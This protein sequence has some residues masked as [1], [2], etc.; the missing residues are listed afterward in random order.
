MKPSSSKREAQRQAD[1][2]LAFR[3]QLDELLR[4]GVLELSA[5]Q[6]SRLDGHLEGRLRELAERFDVD[7]GDSQKRFSL[8]MHILSTLGGLA[9]CAALVLFFLRIWGS[10][11][12]P[13]QVVLLVAAPLVLLPPIAFLA[14]RE[15]TAYYTSLLSLV[16]IA[17]F[18]MNMGVLGSLFNIVPTPGAFLAGGAFALILASA[19]RLRLPLVAGIFSLLIFLA[20]VATSATGAYW[21][22]FLQRPENVLGASL[23][24]LAAIPLLGRRLPAEFADTGRW[25]GLT[26][27]FFS[28]L[29][30]I[31]GGRVSYL[32]LD[33]G[34]VS[35]AYRLLAFA[36]S[37]LTLAL[38]IRRGD[39][40]MMNLAAG[41]FALFLFD[42]LF[43]WWWDWMPKYLFCLIVGLIALALLHVFRKLRLRTREA[44]L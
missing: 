6:R 11:A 7:L 43:S 2:I 32:P 31:H 12:T 10:L 29:S 17:A 13:L 38:G 16:A 8:G 28:L 39:A 26:L 9:F 18:Y 34:T 5:E 20:G 3:Q 14:R 35:S 24:L 44:S 25:I 41:F 23:V 1:R 37:G 15:K 33:A 30:L 4:Q 22:G 19:Y 42:Q 40:G 36:T 27:L 21:Q